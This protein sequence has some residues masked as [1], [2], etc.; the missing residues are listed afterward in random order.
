MYVH[1]SAD[2]F[3][4]NESVVTLVAKAT[5]PKPKLSQHLYEQN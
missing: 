3:R 5:E 1:V 4:G 2:K